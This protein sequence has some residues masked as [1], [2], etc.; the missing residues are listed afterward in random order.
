MINPVGF[1]EQTPCLKDLTMAALHS[2]HVQISGFFSKHLLVQVSVLA[3][4]RKLN[5][6][7]ATIWQAIIHNMLLLSVQLNQYGF[8]IGKI[9]LKN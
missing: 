1:S 7:N 9:T 8:D 2:P 6:S 5:L 3:L 4:N